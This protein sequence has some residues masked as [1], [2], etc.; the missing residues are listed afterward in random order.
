MIA[1]CMIYSFPKK[2]R[3]IRKI[4]SLIFGMQGN[5]QFRYH[6]SPEPE[7]EV[8]RAKI[9]TKECFIN[10]VMSLNRKGNKSAFSPSKTK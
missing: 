8:N 10:S 5:N 4:L 3:E 9:P 7:T 1:N 6:K 2:K